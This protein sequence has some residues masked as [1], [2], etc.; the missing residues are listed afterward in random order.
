MRRSLF[1]LLNLS[2]QFPLV[3]LFFPLPLPLH[4]SARCVTGFPNLPS[5]PS[6]RR[7]F[8]NTSPR[9]FVA[10]HSRCRRFLF[11][12]LH[13]S[14]PSVNTFLPSCRPRL[15][16]HRSSERS[17]WCK[18]FT[19]PLNA[20]RAFTPC[21]SSTKRFPSISSAGKHSCC[22]NAR[23][24]AHSPACRAREDARYMRRGKS[25]TRAAVLGRNRQEN[26]GAHK[27]DAANRLVSIYTHTHP[28][29]NLQGAVKL[30]FP[31][32]SNT[33]KNNLNG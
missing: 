21:A 7:C 26:T 14:S 10:P 20:A 18:S 1:A 32:E 2:T 3:S 5:S 28:N 29:T 25:H 23:E 30:N 15:R 31:S 6:S 24:D 4:P 17:R 8:E 16:S 19:P 13:S 11:L 22:L 12:L 27:G 33:L 9:L